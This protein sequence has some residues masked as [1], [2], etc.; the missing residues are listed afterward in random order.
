M[1][2]T[3]EYKDASSDQA[4]KKYSTNVIEPATTGRDDNGSRYFDLFFNSLDSWKMLITFFV[5]R[6][7]MIIKVIVMVFNRF[8]CSSFV[9][10]FS[11]SFFIFKKSQL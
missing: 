9:N 1:H 5:D 8:M 3:L 10:V 6:N 4:K 7:F 2:G 11:K